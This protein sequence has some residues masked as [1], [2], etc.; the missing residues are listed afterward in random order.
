MIGDGSYPLKYRLIESSSE[1]P[2]YPL[3]EIHKGSKGA[4]WRSVRYCQYPQ[5]III[6]FN[7]PVNLKQIS[8]LLHEKIIPSQ[9]KFFSFVPKST[10][11]YTIHYKQ[12]PFNYTGFIKMDSNVRNNY[13]SREFRKVYIDINCLYLKLVIER[14]YVNRYNNFNQ[15]C[16]VGIEFS[17]FA[18]PIERNKQ[19][20]INEGLRQYNITDADLEGICDDKLRELKAKMESAIKEERYD[21]C[22]RIKANLDR[23]RLLGKRIFDLENKKTLAVNNEDFDAAKELKSQVE[24]MKVNL[25]NID[26]PK[27]NKQP[28]PNIEN[29]KEEI[30]EEIVNDPYNDEQQGNTNDNSTIKSRMD[31]ITSTQG[32]INKAQEDNMS[33]YNNNNN[34]PFKNKYIKEE[35]LDNYDE[36]VLLNYIKHLK[37]DNTDSVE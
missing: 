23:V 29:S 36:L 14:N 19:Q 12:V 1:D 20:F 6:Q 34:N 37:I 2:D 24:K 30:E 33:I 16:L 21:D 35:D 4:G 17:G 25:S 5:E 31:Y 11:E 8:L 22:K 13:R 10:E 27:D 26:K 32:N 28:D 3:K 18:I 7:Q 9:I 15:V